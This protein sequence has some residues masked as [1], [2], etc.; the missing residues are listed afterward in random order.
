MEDYKSETIITALIG[1]V[2]VLWHQL[3]KQF[4]VNRSDQKEF[5]SLLHSTIEVVSASN[6]L[7]ID[8]KEIIKDLKDERSK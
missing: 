7:M 6:E 2:G 1:G 4:G 8:L 3:I 5:T